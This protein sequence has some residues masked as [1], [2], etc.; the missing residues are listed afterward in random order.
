MK[1]GCGIRG[2]E[3]RPEG[4]PYPGGGNQQDESREEEPAQRNANGHVGLDMQRKKYLCRAHRGQYCVK[5]EAKTFPGSYPV[6]ETGIERERELERAENKVRRRLF[7]FSAEARP[8]TD[9]LRHAMRRHF[10][11][12]A[13]GILS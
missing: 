7:E 3:E 13:A 6:K 10:D 2:K 4:T 5:A 11:A 1:E 12:A 9:A 8:R